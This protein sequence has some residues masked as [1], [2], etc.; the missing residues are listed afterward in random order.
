MAA[1]THRQ[2][3][4]R[5]FT[6][7][8]A[9]F[10]DRR[11]N[12]VF[13]SDAA[14]LFERLPR[15]VNDLALDVAAGTGHAARQLAA[16]V[17]AVVAVD[18]TEAMLRQGREAALAGGCR[19]I[20]FLRGDAAD[21]P[22]LDDSFEIAVCRFAVHHFERPEAPLAEMRRCLR[23]GGRLAVADLVAD[24][25]ADTATAAVQN[26]LERLRDPSHTRMLGADEL[27]ELVAAVGCDDVSLER[28]ALVRPLAPWLDQAGAGPDV[29]GRIRARLEE[30]MAGGPATGFAPRRVDGEIWFAQTFASCIGTAVR[31]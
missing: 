4:E 30:E 12:R 27:R 13:T 2:R 8:A 24:A 26:E 25:D 17:R 23:P 29:A 10:E 28:R 16:D 3:I 20:V 31:G 1:D 19:N 14:W 7:Q 15:G 18:A 5:A 11:F 6:D 21:L 9:A 22:F